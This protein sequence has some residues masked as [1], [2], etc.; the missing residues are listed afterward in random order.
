MKE[1]RRRGN[2][3]RRRE[4]PRDNRREAPAV[5]ENEGQ[6]EGR[7]ALTEAQNCHGGV[8]LS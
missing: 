7:N 1:E 4:N 5:E 8:L 2:F 3:D 6:L